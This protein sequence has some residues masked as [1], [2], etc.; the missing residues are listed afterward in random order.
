[1][2][3]L[4]NFILQSLY[5][6]GKILHILSLMLTSEFFFWGVY[7]LINC[8]FVQINLRWLFNDVWQHS[9]YSYLITPSPL[10]LTIFCLALS[11]YNRESIILLTYIVYVT[12][13]EFLIIGSWFPYVS[14]GKS[15]SIENDTSGHLYKMHIVKGE[16]YPWLK[17]F[18]ETPAQRYPLGK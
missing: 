18:K 14:H 5:C 10:Q 3:D 17:Y 11:S 7:F 6:E 8:R 2:N 13:Q 12:C 9:I 4:A 15:C 1:M 16:R